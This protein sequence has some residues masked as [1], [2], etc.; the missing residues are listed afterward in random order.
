MLRIGLTGGI[1][2]GKTAV[3]QIFSD[4][5]FFIIDA[6]KVAR[7]VVQPGTPALKELVEKFGPEILKEGGRLNRQALALIAFSDEESLNF[8]NEVT[9]PRIREAIKEHIKKAQNNNAHAILFDVPLLVESELY[10]D[11]LYAFDYIIVV[12]AD[13]ETRVH[14]LVNYRNMNEEDVR[15]RIA[16][17]ANDTQR[18]AIA[19]YIINNNGDLE[20]LRTQVAAILHNV[21]T[22]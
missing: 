12:T 7:E 19:D 15:R 10:N 2:S 4:H 3:T 18:N 8:L 17:Q 16:A 21:K 20:D 14:R 13:I 9:H 1:G 11:P 5:G 6:D 22:H